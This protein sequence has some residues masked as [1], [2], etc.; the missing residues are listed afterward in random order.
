MSFKY[1]D[2]I[3][4]ENVADVAEAL[5]NEFDAQQLN[6]Q[7]KKNTFDQIYGGNPYEGD[8]LSQ[9]EHLSETFHLKAHQ[10][11]ML[12]FLS[13]ALPL[14]VGDRSYVAE[15]WKLF[16]ELATKPRTEGDKP[17]EPDFEAIKKTVTQRLKDEGFETPAMAAE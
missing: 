8:G 15:S 12:Y 16:K 2:K 9:Q 10:P 11:L 14:V 17:L 3:K 7:P 6:A 5:K 13:R 4:A 1:P